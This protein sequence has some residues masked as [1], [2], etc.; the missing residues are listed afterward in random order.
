MPPPESASRQ[1]RWRPRFSLAALFVLITLSAV[2]TWYWYQ[3]PFTVEN[4]TYATGG[5]DPFA[6]PGSSLAPSGAKGVLRRE[7]QSVRR[8]LGGDQ[9]TLRHGP[10]RVFDGLGVLLEEGHYQ[11]GVKHGRFAQYFATG[12]LRSEESFERGQLQGVSRRWNTAYQLIEET[13]YERGQKHGRFFRAD[14]SGR[15]EIEG[16]YERDVPAEAWTWRPP[17]LPYLTDRGAWAKITGQ[18]HEGLPDGQW[19]CRDGANQVYLTV[20]FDRGRLIA[21]KPDNFEPRLSQLLAQGQIVDPEVVPSLFRLLRVSFTDTPLHVVAAYLSKASGVP[22]LLGVH[23]PA[24]AEE[25]AFA[26]QATDSPAGRAPSANLPVATDDPFAGLK[27]PARHRTNLAATWPP[28]DLVVRELPVTMERYEAPIVCVLGEV[29]TPRGFACDYRFG[30]LWIDRAG[31]IAAWQDRTGIGQVRPPRSS[32]LA[33]VWDQPMP[34]GMEFVETPAADAL[35]FLTDSQPDLALDISA[36]PQPARPLPVRPGPVLTKQL[37]PISLK[38][39]NLP[40]KHVLGIILDQAE[41]RAQ[42]RGDTLVIVPRKN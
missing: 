5:S 30:V 37:R 6:A 22:V 23:G 3:L 9:K 40:L 31:A 32:R 39:R 21:A 7:V 16:T 20:H 2:G 35:T 1:K 25:I 8:V 41:C 34:L 38:V 33:K 36:L 27:S 28:G 29:L 13:H 18:W 14:S 17:I 12:K 26:C 24:T 42:L 4:V 10:R 11:N 19:V 15:R